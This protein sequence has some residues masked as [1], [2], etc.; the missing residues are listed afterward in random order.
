MA[1]YKREER[2]RPVT[3][4]RGVKVLNHPSPGGGRMVTVA[5]RPVVLDDGLGRPTA[6]LWALHAH[7]LAAEI[8]RNGLPDQYRYPHPHERVGESI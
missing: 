5:G 4:D 8:R 6:E 1:R 7:N 3:H 2:N